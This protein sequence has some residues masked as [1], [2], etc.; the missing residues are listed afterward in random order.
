METIAD[1]TARMSAVLKKLPDQKT[2][3]AV[4][5]TTTL[6]KVP[7]FEEHDR[8]AL[9]TAV[10]QGLSM[11]ALIEFATIPPYLTALWSIIDQ[12]SDVARSIRGIV[13]EEMG[14]FAIVSNILVALGGAPK[15][16]GSYAPSYPCRLPGGVHPE[17]LISLSSLSDE[18]LD[19]FIELER[20]DV[21]VPI[22]GEVA[23]PAPEGDKTLGE[24]YEMLRASVLALRPEFNTER[25]IAGPLVPSVVANLDDFGKAIDLIRRQGEGATGEPFDSDPNDLA[26]FYRFKAIKLGYQ[27]TWDA[28]S[29]LLRKGA[30][31][32]MPSVVP[33]AL[34]P[35]GRYGPATPR[36]VRDLASEFNRH[37]SSLLD[38]LEAAWSGGGHDRLLFAIEKMFA[39]EA[40]ARDLLR[41]ARPDGRGYVPD[42]RYN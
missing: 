19:A 21:V 17:L 37:Y 42:F 33:A 34:P 35:G 31:L 9:T 1:I 36:E 39:L 38:A 3:A 11:A 29:K 23:M 14:H 15:L 10:L 12:K 7:T 27:L 16:T 28:E 8:R 13:H 5:H 22:D 24:F 30:A 32:A 6:S 20:P 40:I 4:S 26:H 18:S 41:H 25:Q 2:W